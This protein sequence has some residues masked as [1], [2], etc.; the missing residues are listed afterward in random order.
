MIEIGPNLTQAIRDILFTV[1]LLGTLVLFVV[2][3][4][5]IWE[6]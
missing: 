4:K 6:S 5:N 3:M 1:S 2:I